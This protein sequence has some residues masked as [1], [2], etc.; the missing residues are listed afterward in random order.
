M[1]LKLFVL[2]F[3]VAVQNVFVV[4]VAAVEVVDVDVG[5]GVVL[6]YDVCDDLVDYVVVVAAVVVVIM[7]D[8]VIATVVVI[9]AVVVAIYLDRSN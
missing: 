8:F 1:H 6:V 7:D 5:H 4:V 9:V 2:H 3:V